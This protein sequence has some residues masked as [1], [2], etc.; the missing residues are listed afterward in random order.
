MSAPSSATGLDRAALGLGDPAPVR[1]VHLGL[2]AFHRSHQ[3]WYTHAVDA[4]HSWGIAAFTGRNP[5]A[6]RALAAQDGLYTLVTRSNDGDEY[7]VVRS[8]SAAYDGA[9]LGRLCSLVKSP[10]TAIITI[11]VTEAAYHLSSGRLNLE[12]APVAEDV[13]LLA[14]WWRTSGTL[15]LPEDAGVEPLPTTMGA[16]VLTGLDA[17]RRAG[18]GPLAVVSCDNL[19]ANG[20]AASAA[21]HGLA[22]EVSEELADWVKTNVSFVDTS[23]DRITPRTTD[24]DVHAIAA[25]TGIADSSPVITEPFHNWVLSGEFP[26]GRPY[27]EK[28]GALFVDE[29]DHFE[30]RKLWLLNGAHSLLAY[31]GQLLG[32]CTVAESMADTR[33]AAWVD[34][35]WDEASAHL[36]KPDL[37]VPEYRAA[38]LKR[39][40]NSRIA[41]QLSQIA[42]DG[43]GKIRLRIL[44]VMTAERAAGRSGEGSARAIA[45]W[46]DY[47][48]AGMGAWRED[49]EAEALQK[50]VQLEGRDLTAAMVMHLD[51][52]LDTDPGL[53]DFIHTLRGAW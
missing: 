39:F 46:I 4:D 42:A 33:C 23:V 1:I 25:A 40:G 41:H 17:R 49:A 43:S 29:I 13:S 12:A 2:G 9:D 15:A 6:A 3:A 26:A 36:M 32:H 51:S 45:A 52:A 16:R 5:D 21:I 20:A 8:I 34:S 27:W 30:R 35:F 37:R 44:P 48:K 53:V 47:L 19:S 31:A 18:S 14:G 38:L 28:A 10:G 50:L 11:T 24:A 7:E 22:L